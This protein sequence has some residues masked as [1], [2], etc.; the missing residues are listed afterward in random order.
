MIALVFI[1]FLAFGAI[2]KLSPNTM[3]KLYRA[4]YSIL[5]N[6]N[7]NELNPPFSTVKMMM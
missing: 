1:F 3:M 5:L 4:L 6:K 7:P 2:R